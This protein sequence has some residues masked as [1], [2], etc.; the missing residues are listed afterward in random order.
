[1]SQLYFNKI[2]KKKNT[3][4]IPGM[5]PMEGQLVNSKERRVE[6]LQE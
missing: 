3:E 2:K 4:T 6:V 1:M 5:R